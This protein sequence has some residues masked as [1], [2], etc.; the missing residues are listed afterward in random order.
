MNIINDFLLPLKRHLNRQNYGGF[1][2]I[3]QRLSWLCLQALLILENK[4]LTPNTM[5]LSL[6]E[7]LDK[8]RACSETSCCKLQI[9][10]FLLT[11]EERGKFRTQF[12]VVSPKEKPWT[13]FCTAESV[14]M[15]DSRGGS[16]V[17]EWGG[18]SWR[19]REIL[20]I[21][22]HYSLKSLDFIA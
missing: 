6:W 16:R 3:S 11:A 2:F 19:A 10:F 5:I 15:D 21:N 13:G 20:L 17:W 14:P 9:E 4:L 8:E 7:R 22:I 1:P 18:Q 12:D